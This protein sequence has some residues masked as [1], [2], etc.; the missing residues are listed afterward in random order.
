MRLKSKSAVSCTRARPGPTTED[1]IDFDLLAQPPLECEL[2]LVGAGAESAEIV[3]GAVGKEAAILV[4]DRD[5]GRLQAVD[6][7]GHQMAD[8]AHL[9]L[10]QRAAELEHDRGGGLGLVA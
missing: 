5:P 6:R 8:G 1:T 9:L 7:G 3:V 4:D 10:L 2:A